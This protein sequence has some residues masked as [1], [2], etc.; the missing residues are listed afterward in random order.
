MTWLAAAHRPTL[1]SFRDGPHGGFV[2]QRSHY[3]LG[4]A[5]LHFWVRFAALPTGFVLQSGA[6]NGLLYF[7]DLDLIA[8]GGFVLQ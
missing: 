8:G 2:L 6:G 7:C 4:V 3:G 5:V 1:G